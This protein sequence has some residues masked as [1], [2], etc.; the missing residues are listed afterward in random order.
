MAD[1]TVKIYK[2]WATDDN[3]RAW[4]NTYEFTRYE[5]A[6]DV[7]NVQFGELVSAVV[8]AEREIHLTSVY[9]LRAVVSTWG[10][11]A[12][13]DAP[14]NFVSYPIGLQGTRTQT[15][16][17]ID[18]NNVFFV[19]RAAG[20]GRYGKIFYRG[21]LTEADVQSG[22][23]LKWR[24]TPT[25]T[26]ASGGADWTAYMTSM[27]SVLADGFGG[28]PAVMALIAAR[29]LAITRREVTSLTP[30][31]VRVNKANHK[32]FNKAT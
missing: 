8:E 1:V 7:G 10:V 25:S 19:R 24:L 14:E 15:G 28:Q 29:G 3:E 16:D 9:F 27:Q 4:A 30:A 22:A 21:C 11:D 26:L 13:E 18:R 32:Y 20:F 31:G 17:A 5:G 23:D 6:L 2:S 12:D